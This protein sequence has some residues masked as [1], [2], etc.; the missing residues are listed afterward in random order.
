MPKDFNACVSGGG[1]VR[2]K[3]IGK[4]K[5]AHI[6]FKDGKSYIG[7]IKTRKKKTR[8]RYTEELKNE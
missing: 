6:C 5:Y 7:E 8:N 3:R 2:T 1:R 4:T